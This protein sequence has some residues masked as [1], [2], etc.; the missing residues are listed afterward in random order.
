MGVTVIYLFS[1]ILNS[2]NITYNKESSYS[3]QDF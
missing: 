3:F 2:E 1:I